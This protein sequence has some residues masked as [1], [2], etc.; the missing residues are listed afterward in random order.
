[1]ILEACV[2]SK[3]GLISAE[4]FN[5]QR[6]EIC[7]NLELDGLTPSLELQ[8]IGRLEFKGS[9]Y[10]M[11]RPHANGFFYNSKHLQEMKESI[12]IAKNCGAE[13]V[14]F[15]ALKNGKIDF[16]VNEELLHTAQQLNL[17]CTF[18]K[19]IDM[20]NHIKQSLIELSE[21]GFDWV[22]TSGGEN[23][24]ELGI[25]N[26]I[27]MA[28]IPN[29]KVKILVG[30]GISPSNCQKFKNIGIDGLHF[31]IDK[32]KTVNEDKIESILE[33]I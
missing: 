5:I 15:G 9:K 20:C 7:E 12:Q 24:A 1:M 21:M 31:S 30:G 32:N 11:I 10:I 28:N 22:L 17:K 18:H 2:S 23:N 33:N 14:V 19:A 16:K 29:R 27:S 26:L 4:K 25:K 3:E 13:G 6:V 8:N